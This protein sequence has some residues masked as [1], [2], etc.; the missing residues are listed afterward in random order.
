MNEKKAKLK[1][2]MENQR[3]AQALAM[4]NELYNAPFKIRFKFCMKL[5]F[6]K[7]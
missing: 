1:R 2:F 4:M 6:G 7:H 5:L 3:K